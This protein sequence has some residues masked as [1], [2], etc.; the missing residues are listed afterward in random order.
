M[1]V[2]DLRKFFKELPEDTDEME[3]M[4]K[5]PADIGYRDYD[6]L[7]IVSHLH[8]VHSSVSSRVY[9]F[10]DDGLRHDNSIRETK[11]FLILVNV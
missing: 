5:M 9:W 3:I 6:E 7:P 8:R 2:K 1:K 10:D 4:I 11:N